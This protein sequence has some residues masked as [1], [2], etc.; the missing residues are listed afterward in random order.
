MN[1]ID[2][3]ETALIAGGV[4]IGFANTE[5]ILGIIILTVQVIWLLFKL[6]YK[7]YFMVKNRDDPEKYNDDVDTF[8]ETLKSI[9]SKIKIGG[10]VN[11]RANKQK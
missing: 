5:Q 4:V 7:L 1:T 10:D 2:K 3:I 8:L 9:G 6:G 11:E